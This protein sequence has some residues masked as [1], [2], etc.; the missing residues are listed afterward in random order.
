MAI[1]F[2]APILLFLLVMTLF[3]G[4]FIVKQQTAVVI[5]RFGRFL[6]V[7]NSGL[8]FKIPFFDRVAGRVNLKIQQLDV[9][10]ETKTKD[11]VFVKLKVSVQFKVLS[12]NIYDSFYKLE[13][14]H[15][16]ITSYVFDVV[17]AEVPKMKLDDVFVRKDDIALAIKNELQEAMT[18]YGYHIVKALV[19]MQLNVKNLL[20]NMK[21]KRKELR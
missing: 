3:S 6:N 2:Y 12:D 19:T 8:Q 20:Q 15:E 10:V 17:R 7:R 16:Q 13:N 5:E 21:Q 18:D 11:D 9:P 4:L 1:P 14:P